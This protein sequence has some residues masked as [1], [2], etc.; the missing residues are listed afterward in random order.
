MI[1]NVHTERA[2]RARAIGLWGATAGGDG[3]RSSGIRS[4]VDV[5]SMGGDVGDD[6]RPHSTLSDLVRLVSDNGSDDRVGENSDGPRDEFEVGE[7]IEAE[8]VRLVRHPRE[9]VGR[10]KEV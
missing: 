7:A 9:E 8:V 6:M 2:E 10:L 3:L 5:A 1:S 4:R